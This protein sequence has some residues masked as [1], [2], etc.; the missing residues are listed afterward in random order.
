MHHMD[1]I[2]SNVDALI[3][4]TLVCRK[5]RIN[6]IKESDYAVINNEKS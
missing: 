3:Y 6:E 1:T 5:Y 2:L 4:P